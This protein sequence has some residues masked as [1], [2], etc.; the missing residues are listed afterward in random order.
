MKLDIKIQY[1]LNGNTKNL[2]SERLSPLEVS[3]IKRD[4]KSFGSIISSFEITRSKVNIY[5]SPESKWYEARLETLLKI[6]LKDPVE[7]DKVERK[8]VFNQGLREDKA[9]W[10]ASE[11]RW[12]ESEARDKEYEEKREMRSKRYSDY[13]D[14]YG[15]YIKA[16]GDGLRDFDAPDVDKFYADTEYKYEI[17]QAEKVSS[18]ESEVGECRAGYLVGFTALLIFCVLLIPALSN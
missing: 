13:M 10:K 15:R 6:A 3:D 14:A 5:E 2:S 8:I 16:W 4:L 17:L 1:I 9:W 7:L 12:E 11:A 18:T